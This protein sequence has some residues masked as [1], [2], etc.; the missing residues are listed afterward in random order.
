MR[1]FR[2]ETLEKTVSKAYEA[3]LARIRA[4]PFIL[5]AND[6]LLSRDQSVRWIFCAG[7]ESRSFP[8]ILEQMICKCTDER[9]KKIL[10]SNLDDEF[11]N[12]DP[13]HAHFKHY[14]D[15]LNR[16]AIPESEFE[17]YD[18]KAGIGLALALA[19]N[20]ASAGRMPVALGYML[21]N[22]GMTPITYMAAKQALTR[23]FPGLK[24][25]FFDLHISIDELHVGELI[26]ALGTMRSDDLDDVLFGIELG[27]RGMAALLDEAFGMFDHAD[28][29]GQ[30]SR[31]P[32]Y[33]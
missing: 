16:L 18:E 33:A 19:Y 2:A 25:T 15:L 6:G 27:E 14:L 24:T 10:Q 13:E 4:H 1:A 7:R 28:R 29:T 9:V 8:C 21:V 17:G 32:A 22:E 12:G 30:A 20:I 26:R 5:G 23:H 3:S 31:Q 11:G